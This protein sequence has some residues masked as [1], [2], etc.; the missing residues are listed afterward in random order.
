MKLSIVGMGWQKGQVTLQGMQEIRAADTVVLK[1]AL[2]PAAQT[3]EE[4][5]VQY[6]SCDFLFDESQDFCALDEAIAAFLA[7]QKGKVVFCV[8]GAGT[9]DGTARLLH[10]R[11]GTKIIPGVADCQSVLAEKP[12]GSVQTFC[13]TDLLEAKSVSTNLPLIVTEVDDKFL[14]CAV[15]EKLSRF[16]DGEETCLFLSDGKAHDIKI[17][18]IDRQKKY[19]RDAAL[20]IEPLPLTQKKSFEVADLKEILRVL[21]SENGCPWDKVQT[22][23]SLRANVLEEAYELVDAIDSGDADGMVEETGDNLLQAY[24]HICLAEESGEFDEKEV[25]TGICKKLISRHTHIFGTDKAADSEQ[26]LKVW[27]KNK[28]QEKGSQTVAQEMKRSS[29]GLPSALK[30]F[31]VQKKAAKNRFDWDDEQGLFD[32]LAEEAQELKAAVTS[33]EK[34]E[35][36][37]DL[38]FQCVNVCRHCGVD[39]EVAL[40][41]AAQKFIRRFEFVENKCVEAFGSLEAAPR[42][43]MEEFWNEAKKEGL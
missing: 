40:N 25:L 10:E 42:D 1:T 2:T 30:A 15:K 31:K 6:V 38:L 35:E 41:K 26:A 12:Q 16:F 36:A 9:D 33:Q 29:K 8:N 27:E 13:A 14:A 32:K 22:H 37:G 23:E 18:E 34:E 21:R 5:G 19:G 24:F 3:L 17:F 11:F 43:E 28:A 39:P 7:K 4:E 20:L